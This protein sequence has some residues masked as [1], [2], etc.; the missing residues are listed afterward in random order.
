ME[1]KIRSKKKKENR[2][3]NMPVLKPNAAGIDV[4]DTLHAVAVPEGRDEESVRTFGSMTCDLLDLVDWLKKCDVDTVAMESTGVYW[5][6][7]FSLLINHGIEVFLVHAQHVRNVTGKKTDQ[8]DAQW[9]QQLHSCGL[10]KSC[11]LP[12]AEQESL[13]ALVRYRRSLIYDCNRYVLRIQKSLELMNI[14]IHTVLANIISKTG[15]AILEAIIGGERNPENFLKFVDKRVRAKKEILVKSLEGNWMPEYLYLLADYY[16]SYQ[17]VQERIKACE[18][19]ILC[20][21]EKYEASINEGVIVDKKMVNPEEI[22]DRFLKRKVL[23]RHPTLNTMPYIERIL[24]VNVFAIYGLS[25]IGALEV[26]AETGKDLSKWP[27]EKHFVSWLNLCPNT[28]ISGGK[29]LSS[30]IQKKKPNLASQ[31]FRSAANG[32]QKSDHWLGNYFR[33]MRAKGGQRYAIVATANKIA[34]I[35]YKMVRY[36]KEFNPVD[37]KEYQEKYRQAKIMYLEK[38]LLKLKETAATA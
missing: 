13:R 26:L 7:L 2:F 6:P 11:F 36:Q 14:K 29:I 37:L 38:R 24:G 33:R 25:D 31:A 20:Q 32:V 9:L 4:G 16:R 1:K 27:T 3:V 23:K 21:L 12:D 17:Y 30:R 35:Y 18:K 5:K 10:L 34:T 22:T 15:I 8:S 28:K 19:E